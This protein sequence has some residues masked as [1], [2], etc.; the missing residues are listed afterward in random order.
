M[1]MP[2]ADAS[3]HEMAALPHSGD[4]RER[5]LRQIAEKHGF[6]LER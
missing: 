2:G 5:W 4:R 6:K 3:F 1:R